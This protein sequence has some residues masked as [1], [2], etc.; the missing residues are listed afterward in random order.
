MARYPGKLSTD[1]YPITLDEYKVGRFALTKE[2]ACT[3]DADGLLDGTTTSSSAVTTVTEFLNAM[4]YPRSVTIIASDNTAE[5]VKADSTCTITG[6]GIDNKVISEVL[7]FEENQSTAEETTK[8]FKTVTKVVFSIMDGAAKFDVG[9]GNKLGLPYKL[10]SV[11]HCVAFQANALETTAP[12]FAVD[13]DEIEKNTVK[14][15]TALD[16]TKAVDIYLFL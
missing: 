12:T 13:D 5:H 6:T 16:S 2:Q 11:P 4:P 7:T 15:N 10:A 8:A 3:L 1:C 14:L 9:W